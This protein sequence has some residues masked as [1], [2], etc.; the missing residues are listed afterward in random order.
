MVKRVNNSLQTYE[1]N[2]ILTVL[3]VV[4]QTRVYSLNNYIYMTNS[5]SSRT[6]TTI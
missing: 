6:D 5:C 3:C 2:K 1:F 4:D